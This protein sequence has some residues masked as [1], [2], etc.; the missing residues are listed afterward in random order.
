EFNSRPHGELYG[1]SPD[2]VLAG[3]MPDKRLFREKIE[4]A[5]ANRLEI[6]RNQVCD[7]C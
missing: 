1:L 5:R 6:N 7:V 2:D 3:K 4:Q